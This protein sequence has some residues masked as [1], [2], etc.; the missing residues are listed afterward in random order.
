MNY[1]IFG[2]GAIGGLLG[3]RLA[4]SGHDV[5]LIARGP[6]LAAIRQ[7]GLRIRSEQFGE[8]TVDAPATDDTAEAP[9]SDIVILSVKAT[10]LLGAIP[11]I[12]P[13]LAAETTVITLQNGL[14][15][16]FFD[17]MPEP[18]G[19]L[20]LSSLDPDGALAAALPTDR[21]LG[22]IAYPSATVVEPG[23]IAHTE[24]DRFTLG[25]P[26]GQLTPRAK[27]IAADWSAAGFKAPVK[28][29]IRSEIWLK[30]L[31]NAAVNP[32]G[33]LAH[34]TVQQTMEA[35]AT[36]ELVANVMAEVRTIGT[37]VGAKFAVSNERRMAGLDQVGHHKTSMV[38]DLE[39]G[40]HGEVD[41]ILGA[42]IEV[43]G[44]AGIP[45]PHLQ[46]LYACAS[47][48]FSNR[49]QGKTCSKSALETS[50]RQTTNREREELP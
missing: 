48:L 39:A 12:T 5:T 6:H 36:R 29:D 4:A 43:A 17:G 49:S 20:R 30:I 24:G 37:A 47:L 9:P 15:W 2:A 40:R 7:N 21:V 25:E 38:Q 23:V 11:Q 13:L 10:A 33:T 19:G 34:A 31:G 18:W 50:N 42:V 1:T 28:T 45:C 46:T 26:S 14:P 16:W 8:F 3:A 41:A 35:P 44:H 22:G 27:K 32:I